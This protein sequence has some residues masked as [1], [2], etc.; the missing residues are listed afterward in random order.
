MNH[1]PKRL[2]GLPTATV[3]SD[4]VTQNKDNIATNTSNIITLSSDTNSLIDELGASVESLE[5]SVVKVTGT[6]AI[7]GTKTFEKIGI[8]TSNPVYNLDLGGGTI[9]IAQEHEGTAIRVG[10]G[11]GSSNTNIWRVDDDVGATDKSGYGFNLQYSGVGTGNDNQMTMLCDDKSSS[12]QKEGYVIKQDGTMSFPSNRDLASLLGYYE[13][14]DTG[15]HIK[16][17]TYSGSDATNHNQLFSHN[18][19]WTSSIT[20]TASKLTDGVYD[21]TCIVGNMTGGV[22]EDL[23]ISF[24]YIHKQTGATDFD[25]D[26]NV[27]IPA[28]VHYKKLIGFPNDEARAVVSYD[29]RENNNF[30]LFLMWQDLGTEDPTSTGGRTVKIRATKVSSFWTGH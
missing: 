26:P 23:T 15:F 7:T 10:A 8:S 22:I 20:G 5:A 14:T 27:T 17:I 2:N 6:Q 1:Q 25:G 18:N 24:R 11:S 30:R 13:W 9:R 12:V 4:D 21:L 19:N 3:D 28:T 16:G 29:I